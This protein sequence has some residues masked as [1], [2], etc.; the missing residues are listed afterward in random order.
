MVISAPAEVVWKTVSQFGKH[1]LWM[2][3]DHT[4]RSFTPSDSS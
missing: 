2:Y 1:A 4:S 3:A